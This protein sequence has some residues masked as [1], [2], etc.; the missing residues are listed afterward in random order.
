MNPKSR[1]KRR[2]HVVIHTWSRAGFRREWL[3]SDAHPIEALLPEIAATV[4]AM[5]PHLAQARREREEEARLAEERRRQ[6]EEE[7]R[8]RKCDS[9]PWRRFV[10]FARAS[11]RCG[12]LVLSWSNFASSRARRKCLA[13][14]ALTSGS[15][16]RKLVRRPPTRSGAARKR[17]SARLPR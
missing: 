15:L 6:A 9:N 7:R 13:T 16:E 14:V 17:C 12:R 2:L 1:A 5:G 11:E 8:R 10:E 4:L 3:E